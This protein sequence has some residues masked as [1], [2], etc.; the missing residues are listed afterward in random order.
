M[1][2][3]LLAERLARVRETIAAACDGTG[4]DPGEI[5]VVA[6]TKGYP[7]QTLLA[8]VE[9]GFEDI[10]ENR[11]QEAQVKFE[12]AGPAL[13][14]T[15]RHMV[16]HLQ[17]NKVRDALEVFDWI[18]SVDTVRLAQEISGRAASRAEAVGGTVEVD[19]L[20]EVNASGEGQ[21]HGFDPTEAAMMAREIAALPGLRARGVMAMAPYTDD[22]AVLRRTFRI[23]RRV[24]DELRSSAG[25][26][27]DTL[28]MG[29]SNDYPIAIQE[30]STM[31][32]LGTAL[33]EAPER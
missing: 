12:A 29:M 22:E 31:V 24:F 10:G 19:V 33:F 26:R 27:V 15:R 8:A 21:K 5:I 13:A 17:R 23:A 28:S 9:L 1:D 11:V 4:R 2:P 30:G 14:H 16:G 25:E 6:I 3:A 32:R 20:V 18:Q 7:V